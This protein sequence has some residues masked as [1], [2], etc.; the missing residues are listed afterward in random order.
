MEYVVFFMDSGED[1]SL[2]LTRDTDKESQIVE[3][4]QKA[5]P[6]L[7]VT[8][9]GVSV[10]AAFFYSWYMTAPI[11][12]ISRTSRKMA[13]M[14]FSG[15][16]ATARTD[17]IGVLS[18]S[19]NTL[20]QNLSAA[21]AELRDAN[22]RLQADIDRERQMERQRV[23]FFSAASHE[24]KTPVTIIKGQL[25]GMLYQV[26]RYRDRDTYLARSLAV[27]D[28]LEKM[29]Q[30]LLV[31][32]RLDTPGYA[33]ARAELDLSGLLE[34]CLSA[35]EDLFIQKKLSVEKTILRHF[36]LQAISGSFKSTG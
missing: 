35:H 34:K 32:S 6:I 4:L 17:E 30:E 27:T 33:C 14:D 31:L 21:L 10:T 9:L 2:L 20:A 16:C 24:L 15:L 5:L 36:P 25:E 22:Q 19:L 28:T 26:G 29:V 23:E 12:K 18:D 7:C 8:I 11:K 1:Y 3:S 13:E